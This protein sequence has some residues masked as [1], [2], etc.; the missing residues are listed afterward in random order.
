MRSLCNR[1]MMTDKSER[2]QTFDDLYRE[3]GDPW[4]VTTSEY[5]RGK[6]V[7]TLAALPQDRHFRSV[8]DIGCSFGTLTAKLAQRSDHVTAI[9]VSGE[10]ISRARAEHGD[11]ARFE[12]AELP[13]GW[14]DGRFDLIV[15]S[16]VL[17]FLSRA[18]IG[19]MAAFAARDLSPDGL[20]LLVNWTGAND[21]PVGGEEA[22]AL[23]TRTYRSHRECA[24]ET[25]V[26]DEFRIDLLI[27][28][29]SDE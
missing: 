4:H 25:I 28:K 3:K 1:C 27:P 21:L 17:Y 7:S 9:D 12:R 16:E 11:I 5:E 6:Y 20:C 14:P 15:M 10:A 19:Q 29:S 26:H 22:A 13:D 8:L 18:E 23:F 2:E 24:A